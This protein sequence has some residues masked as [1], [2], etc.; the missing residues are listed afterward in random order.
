[1][2]GTWLAIVNGFA[3]LRT[4]AGQ[5]AFN[6]FVPKG[7]E[8]YTFRIKYRGSVLEA[9][10]TREACRFTLISGDELELSVNG[11]KIKLTEKE[12]SCCE[13]I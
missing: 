8:G 12:P 7:W 5:L 9:G 1:M 6:P 13:K 10:M 4:N 3:G 11:K 2:A